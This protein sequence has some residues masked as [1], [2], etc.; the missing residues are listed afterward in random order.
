MKKENLTCLINESDCGRM[1]GDPVCPKCGMDERVVYPGQSDLDVALHVAKA[2]F[3]TSQVSADRTGAKE[4][5][6]E[7]GDRNNLSVDAQLPL[8]Y[9][10]GAIIFLLLSIGY[11]ERNHLSGWHYLSG[12]F[13]IVLGA[14]G[15]FKYIWTALLPFV[16]Y[17]IFILKLVVPYFYGFWVGALS[18]G[19]FASTLDYFFWM[20]FTLFFFVLH[21]AIALWFVWNVFGVIRVARAFWKH[22]SSG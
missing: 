5:L 15:L 21:L 17:L 4:S 10:F 13:C 22:G 20:L 19:P 16:F 11:F 1:A 8:V 18:K 9:F 3:L 2:Q 12:V 7:I 14:W 6:N